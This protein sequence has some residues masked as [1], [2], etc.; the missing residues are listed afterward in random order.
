[1]AGPFGQTIST[2]HAVGEQII[3]GRP[4]RSLRLRAWFHAF[5]QSYKAKPCVDPWL[6][7]TYIASR[8]RNPPSSALR[9][10]TA[11]DSYFPVGVFPRLPPDN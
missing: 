9:N 1:M 6:Y 3:L 5:D 10:G 11:D 8:R 2:G 7:I 4:L